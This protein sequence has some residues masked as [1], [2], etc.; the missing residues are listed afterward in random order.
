MVVRPSAPS[1]TGGRTH[2]P[3][4]L[5]G[6]DTRSVRN[7]NGMCVRALNIEVAQV[8]NFQYFVLWNCA[9]LDLCVSIQLFMFGKF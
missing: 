8:F 2:M 3:P 1:I 9:F 7:S 4:N 5:A 6:G